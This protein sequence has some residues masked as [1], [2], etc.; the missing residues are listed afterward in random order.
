M[1][2]DNNDLNFLFTFLEKFN[3][4]FICKNKALTRKSGINVNIV[5]KN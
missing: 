3:K 4:C 5:N 1:Y 2:Y